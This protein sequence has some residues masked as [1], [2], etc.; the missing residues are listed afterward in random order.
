VPSCQGAMSA[1][2]SPARHEPPQRQRVRPLPGRVKPCR[3]GSEAINTQLSR[4][5][6]YSI[7]SLQG[8]ALFFR[9]LFMCDV[10][11]RP[12]VTFP[13]ATLMGVRRVGPT[14]AAPFAGPYSLRK[15]HKRGC[16][17]YAVLFA[18]TNFL[19]SAFSDPHCRGTTVM[20]TIRVPDPAPGP[21][22]PLCSACGRP[23]R[24]ESSEPSIPYVNLDHFNYVCD[25]GE[26]TD[27]LIAHGD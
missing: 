26:T 20:P 10:I 21:K 25:C 24:L 6:L 18:G 27:K 15:S 1:R 5:R 19:N 9:C 2:R 12:T 8:Q 16:G 4:M 17:P 11:F 22:A 23:M 13:P 14:F 3:T 7:F